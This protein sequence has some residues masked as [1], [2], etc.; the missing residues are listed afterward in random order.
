RHAAHAALRPRAR[1]DRREARMRW[2][3][4]AIQNTLRNRR[5]SLVTVA[6]AAL[7]TAAVLVAGGFALYTYEGLAQ[8]AARNTGHLIVGRPAQFTTDEDT[9]LQWGLDDAA[10]LAAA[11]R[12]DPA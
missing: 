10:S 12:S 6:V 11:L 1:T 7:G 9:P 8:A 4:F 3:T 5:R 2:L